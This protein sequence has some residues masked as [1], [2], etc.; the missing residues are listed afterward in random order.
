[1]SN[2]EYCLDK[3][4]QLFSRECDESCPMNHP[5]FSERLT[6]IAL[7][8]EEIIQLQKEVIDELFNLLS[9]HISA[10]A[11]ELRPIIEKINE[12][13]RKGSEL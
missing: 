10:E 3:E 8:Q 4:C 11:E 7:C 2:C 1:M 6:H 12:A 13:A 5:N 9:M